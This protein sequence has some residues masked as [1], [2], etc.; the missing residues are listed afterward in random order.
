MKKYGLVGFPLTHS[1]S[2]KYFR[3]KFQNENLFQCVY[4]NFEIQNIRELIKLFVKE[5]ELLGIN[6]TIPFKREVIDMLDEIDPEAMKIGAVNTIKVH[7]VEGAIKLAGFNTDV[8]GFES[9]LGKQIT[10]KHKK[11]LILGTGGSSNAVAAALSKNGIE[12]IKV[13]RGFSSEVL[14]YN[15]LTKEIILQ[16]TLIINCT[17][18]GMFPSIDLFPEIPYQH[19]TR[20]HLLYDLIYNPEETVFLL[21]GKEMGAA[22]KNGFEMLCIQAEAS[23]KIWNEK[24]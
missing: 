24:E 7:R 16:H 18:L 12:S 8:I 9:T 6:I 15:Q 2:K 23:W 14:Q 20:N 5:P 22:T 19:I 21:K 3:E 13:S 1:F 4:E 17:P 11:A 10:D